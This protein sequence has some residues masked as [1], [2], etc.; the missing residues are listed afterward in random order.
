MDRIKSIMLVIFISF[1]TTLAQ[2][3]LKIGTDKGI[4]SFYLI[5]TNLPLIA[6][7]VL[8]VVGAILMIIAFR[9]AELSVLYPLFALTYIWVALVSNIYFGE[10]ISAMRTAGLVFVVLGVSFIG[11]GSRKNIRKG[12]KI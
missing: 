12:E 7:A 1:L 11:L 9:G 5:I 2:F 6:G 4:G 8:Y 10:E 3:F